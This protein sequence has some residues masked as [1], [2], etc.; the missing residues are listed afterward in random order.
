MAASFAPEWW[1]NYN[2]QRYSRFPLQNTAELRDYIAKLGFSIY[3]EPAK[4]VKFKNIILS[5]KNMFKKII[6]AGLLVG[7]INFLA[8]T[9]VSKLFGVIFPA[10]NAE[11]QNPNL[12]RPW[13]DPL[14]LLYFIYP[15][16]LGVILAW[17]WNKT[18]TIFGE[19]IRG[20]I[21]FGFAY[22]IIAGIPGMFITYSSF[23]VSL[24]MVLSWTVSGLVAALLAGIIFSKLNLSE[25]KDYDNR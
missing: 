2:W 9:V 17:F 13:S 24:T 18:K 4:V 25:K 20:G 14:M 6:G 3:K 7:L 12:F 15:F 16:L 10:I 1:R 5:Y 19:D 23:Q 8:T 11:Y 22:W 21:K